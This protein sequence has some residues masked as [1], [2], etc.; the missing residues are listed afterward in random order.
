M[1]PGVTLRMALVSAMYRLPATSTATAVGPP[2]WAGAAVAGVAHGSVAGYRGDGAVGSHLANPHAT[3]VRDVEVPSGVNGH[4]VGP[5][6]GGV[7]RRASIAGRA[8]DAGAGHGRDGA[9]ARD[10]ANPQI[11]AV[12]DKEAAGCIECDRR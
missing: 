12:G 10:P 7:G 3:P 8:G 9:I 11:G 2:S 1:P 4:S 6:E 5:T